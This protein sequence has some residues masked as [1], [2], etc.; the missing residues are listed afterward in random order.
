MVM[1]PLFTREMVIISA[2]SGRKLSGLPA[3]HSP[4][5]SPSFCPSRVMHL[6]LASKA[7]QNV[8]LG[9]REMRQTWMI[10][11]IRTTIGLL[12]NWRRVRHFAM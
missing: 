1:E 12:T 5:Y 4:T 7:N 11:D 9:A 3:S 6:L 2:D 10:L 8:G